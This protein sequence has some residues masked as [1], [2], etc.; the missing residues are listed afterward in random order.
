MCYIS[1]AVSYTHLDVYKR[2]GLW[3]DYSVARDFERKKAEKCNR[4]FAALQRWP[5]ARGKFF[6]F[7]FG[8]N[9]SHYLYTWKV[10]FFIEVAEDLFEEQNFRRAPKWTSYGVY[11]R[12]NLCNWGWSTWRTFSKVTKTQYFFVTM[13][14][15]I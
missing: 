7:Y 5:P 12:E 4:G 9:P 13:N 1:I 11:T 2:Q 8:N 6:T 3:W 10:I 15:Q 14:K